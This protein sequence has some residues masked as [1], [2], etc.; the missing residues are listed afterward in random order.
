MEGVS[1]GRWSVGECACGVGVGC[2]GVK[3]GVWVGVG[4][5]VCVWA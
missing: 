1:V 2:V 4:W 3:Y 5:R